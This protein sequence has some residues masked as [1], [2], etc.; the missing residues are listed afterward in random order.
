MSGVTI[1]GKDFTESW[2]IYTIAL[3][4]TDSKSGSSNSLFVLQ[5]TTGTDCSQAAV[6]IPG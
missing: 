6:T 2:G 4:A 3:V 5:V 1:F